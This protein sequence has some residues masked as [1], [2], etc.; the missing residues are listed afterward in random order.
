[1]MCIALVI[2]TLPGVIPTKAEGSL[3]QYTNSLERF[4]LD[5]P[6]NMI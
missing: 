6:L 2:P 1:M 4:S 5:S 3:C